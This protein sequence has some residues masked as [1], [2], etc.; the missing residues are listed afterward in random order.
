MRSAFGY[1]GVFAV[2][3]ALFLCGYYAGRR[4][5]KV[6]ERTSVHYVTGGSLYNFVRQ[7]EPVRVTRSI[8][9]SIAWRA[10]TVYR[11]EPVVIDTVALLADYLLRRDYALDFSN[12]SVGTF[13]VTCSVQENRLLD[14]RSTVVP[15]L[16]YIERT[17]EVTRERMIQPWLLGGTSI[18]FGVQQVSLGIDIGSYKLGIGGVRYN[19]SYSM[20]VLFGVNF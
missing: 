9:T 19:D 1:I 14:V 18:D 10:D 8:D 11:S 20:Q 5:V 15:K 7:P 16:R 3:A 6:V 2:V 12:D 17:Q 13:K 4:S